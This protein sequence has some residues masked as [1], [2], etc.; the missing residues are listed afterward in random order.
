MMSSD[1]L[2]IHTIPFSSLVQ[3]NVGSTIQSWSIGLFINSLTHVDEAPFACLSPW[4][5]LMRIF[6]FFLLSFLPYFFKKIA[7]L[8]HQ[9]ESGSSILKTKT[10]SVVSITGLRCLATDLSLV[11]LKS[12]TIQLVRIGRSPNKVRKLFELTL[13]SAESRNFDEEPS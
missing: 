6:F 10:Q 12:C 5:G 1:Q 9:S 3:N 11:Q 4:V 7:R 2:L 13:N 8:D